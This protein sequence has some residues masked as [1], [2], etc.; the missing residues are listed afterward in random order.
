MSNP[1]DVAVIM[2]ST[3]D[4]EIM[5]HASET[6]DKLGVGHD[7]RAISAHRAPD[8]L[9]EYADGF[10]SRGVKVVIAGAGCAAA[11]PGMLAAKLTIP[12]LGVPI[13]GSA[14]SGM[15]ALYSI[16]Q[17][18]AGIPVGALAIGRHGA[19]NAALLAV[20]ILA[21]SDASLRD[22]LDQYRAEQT[23]AVLQNSDP[24]QNA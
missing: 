15:D 2:G 3:S 9:F 13:A 1:I 17:M 7:V 12:V 16:V 24:R 23:A 8:A 4:W 11:L 21:L 18:P 19:T 10:E 14:L 5:R 6:L 20:S 22:A